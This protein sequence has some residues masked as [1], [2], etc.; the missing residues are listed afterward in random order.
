LYIN[1]ENIEIEKLKF[2]QEA[3]LCQTQLN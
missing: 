2:P 3:I 1:I